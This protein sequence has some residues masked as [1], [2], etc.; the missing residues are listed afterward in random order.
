MRF[1]HVLQ[2]R[3][4]TAVQHAAAALTGIRPYV[5]DPIRMAHHVEIVLDHE[6]RIA[7]A[8]QLIEGAQQRLRVGRV[9]AGRGLV[10]HVH[11]A[12]QVRPDLRGEP[13]PL[14]FPRRQR[15]RAPLQREVAQSEF[16]QGANPLDDV[17][18]DALRGDALFLGE[19]GR[20]AHI[21]GVRVGGAADGDALVAIFARPVPAQRVHV[22]G[23]LERAFG[24]RRQRV[25]KVAERQLR[26]R[27]DVESRESHV[28]RF[29]LEPFAMTAGA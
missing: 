18:R 14:Q 15:R 27:A 22:G 5:H 25:R 19:I 3:E 11:D 26:Q 4:L 1:G 7:G 8:P 12:E 23:G 24:S 10:E 21:G 28:E 2:P 13:Q 6:Q 16:L 17:D 20:A 9:Q 29:G